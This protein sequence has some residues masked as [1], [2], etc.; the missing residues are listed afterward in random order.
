MWIKEIEG[1]QLKLRLWALATED[2]TLLG[3]SAPDRGK[4]SLP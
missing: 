2:G 4:L 3:T 1:S